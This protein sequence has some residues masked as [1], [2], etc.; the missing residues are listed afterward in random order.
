MINC[1]IDDEIIDINIPDNWKIVRLGNISK[2]ISK[3]TTPKGGKDAY[4]SE[5]FN[6]LRGE[7]VD[8]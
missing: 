7:C 1:K 8:F 4:I 3:G 5:G 2:I 6:Y